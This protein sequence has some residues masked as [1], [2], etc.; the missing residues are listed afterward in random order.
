MP[1]ATSPTPPLSQRALYALQRGR[2][3]FSLFWH[4]I[5]VNSDELPLQL[6]AWGAP[7]LDPACRRQAYLKFCGAAYA[8][9]EGA[10]QL[11]ARLPVLE[12]GGEQAGASALYAALRRRGHDADAALSAEQKAESAAFCA[13]VEEVLGAALLYSWYEV[14][15]N[16]EQAIRPALAAGMP[17]PL[18]L[19]M[20]WSI[21]KRA[22]SQLARRR[23]LDDDDALA[24]GEEALRALSVRLGERHFFHGDAPSSLD[25]SAFA[26]LT[27]VLR[28]PL[29]EDR[30]RRCLRGLANL[31]RFCELVEKRFFDG[32]PPPPPAAPAAARPPRPRRPTPTRP[33][34]RPPPPPSG[35]RSSSASSSARATPCS[36]RA[37]PRSS[38]CSPATL[39]TTRKRRTSG[40]PNLIDQF[41]STRRRL[42]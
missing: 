27:A 15:A 6:P 31:T 40:R 21:R 10:H 3:N 32:A 18:S 34:P 12:A 14:G 5:D 23:C 7:S 13:L 19:Y 16:Y 33:P 11:S 22:H 30:L 28:C 38:M 8:V 1:C 24:R 17:L 25:A 41:Y 2:R 9:E 35:R 29:P 36:P 4:H 37:A 20:P 26:Y 39:G 42:P